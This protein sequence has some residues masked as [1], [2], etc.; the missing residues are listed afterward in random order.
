MIVTRARHQSIVVELRSECD[1][2]ITENRELRLRIEQ[3]EAQV[4]AQRLKTDGEAKLNRLM[5][6]ENTHIQSGL[7]DIQGNMASTVTSTKETLSQMG[8]INSDFDEITHDAR[9][10]VASLEKVS[11][12]SEQSNGVVKVLSQH[13]GKINAVLTMIQDISEQTNL[14]ALNAAIEAARAGEAGRGFAVVADEVRGLA[15][16]TRSAISDTRAIIDEMLGNVASVEK[17]SD[18]A[19][20]GVKGVVNGVA[21]LD[22]QINALH[23]HIRSSFQDFGLMAD[24]VFVSLAKLDHVIWKVNTYLSINLREP[25]FQFV[26]HHN[27]RLGKW[28]YEGDG[29]EYFS[30]SA[31]YREL[32]APHAKVHNGTRDVF[33]LIGGGPLDYE[34]LQKVLGEMEDGSDK[35]FASLDHIRD[36]I[37]ARGIERIVQR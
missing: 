6:S 9:Q 32:E 7:T 27:C 36:D 8:N 20:D 5:T 17:S 24:S 2:Y 22:G 25:A 26:D 21:N 12:I 1:R 30:S 15:V 10:I 18:E 35:V 16:K 37:H 28:Y 31:F 3:L 29:R 14:L 11:H 4:Q 13:A 23:Q 19:L 34:A 33:M